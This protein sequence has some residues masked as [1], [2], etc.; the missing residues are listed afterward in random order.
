MA[1]YKLIYFEEEARGEPAR[2]IFAA[3]G[4]N[5]EDVRIDEWEEWPNRKSSN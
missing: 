5:F 3:A 2:M 1:T 4:V